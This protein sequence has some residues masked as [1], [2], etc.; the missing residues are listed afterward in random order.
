MTMH[1]DTEAKPADVH[2][3]IQPGDPSTNV[4]APA[5]A[6]TP[7]VEETVV[8]D[9]NAILVRAAVAHRNAERA[10]QADEAA[11]ADV[12][13]VLGRK[14]SRAVMNP[15][16]PDEEFVQI[17]VSKL[18]YSAQ[19]VDRTATE[20]WVKQRYADKVEKVTRVSS[21]TTGQDI[22]NVLKQ[23][24]PYL[25]DL[26]VPVVPDNVIRE[27]ELKSQK[28]QRPAGFGGEVDEDAPPGIVVTPS[29]PKV[30]VTFRNADVVD[31]L[32]I[33]KVVDM[34]GNLLGGAE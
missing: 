33:N 10:K 22:I 1:M 24:A 7:A 31:E 4:E 9:L 6:E 2:E 30:Y 3:E 16:R 34:E 5:V 14:G 23:F 13:K 27:L 29:T 19:T 32:L 18:T 28:A 17:T 21:T 25:L 20:E 15:L 11:T 8:K 12:V 26:D